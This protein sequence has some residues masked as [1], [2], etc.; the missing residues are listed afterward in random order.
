MLGIQIALLYAA[1]T[2]GILDLRDA[3]ENGLPPALVVSLFTLFGMYR[4]VLRQ[5]RPER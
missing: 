3:L 2:V 4:T 1:V 5:L